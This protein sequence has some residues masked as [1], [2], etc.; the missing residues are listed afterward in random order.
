MPPASALPYRRDA[1][2]S[3]RPSR[4]VQRVVSAG[5]AHVGELFVLAHVNVQVLP[6]DIAGLSRRKVWGLW[7]DQ[8]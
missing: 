4:E 7:A 3:T 5:G 2:T 1:S 6:A 8:R